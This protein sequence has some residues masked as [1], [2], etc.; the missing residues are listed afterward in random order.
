MKIYQ[1]NELYETPSEFNTALSTKVTNM[2]LMFSSAYADSV[3]ATFISYAIYN[4]FFED[5]VAYFSFNE[6]EEVALAETKEKFITRLAYDVAVK[7]PYWKTK[8][9]YILKLFSDDELNLLQS[10]RMKSSS[11]ERVDSAGGSFQ[12][13][14]STPTGVNVETLT[15]DEL[16]I[17]TEGSETKTEGTT[18][19][20]LN[21]SVSS[22]GFVDKYTN[23]QGKTNTA[24]RTSGERSGDILREGSIDEL[25][26]VLERLPSSF[27]DEITKEVFYHFIFVY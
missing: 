1:L 26:K 13:S 15:G 17:T 7:F 10:S 20:E 11:S 4:H 3:Y 21:T 23:Y 18:E 27:A 25:L 16:N 8:Y 9:D 6:D 2:N 14:A 12:K 22:S 24:S 5:R 19:G